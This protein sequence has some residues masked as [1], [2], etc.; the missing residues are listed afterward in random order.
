MFNLFKRKN[1]IKELECR[2]AVI[3]AQVTTLNVQKE[4]RII[5]KV[6]SSEGNESIVTFKN[7][8]ITLAVNKPV[9]KE[10]SE[11]N[12][13]LILQIDGDVVGKVVLN[14]LNK[15][16]RQGGISLIPV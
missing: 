13:D 15:K 14:Q 16:Q 9:F 2:V 6:Y 11:T 7:G 10:K 8:D 12:R 3:E 1:K 5:H 4:N